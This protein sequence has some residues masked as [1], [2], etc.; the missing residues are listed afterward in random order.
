[1]NYE[2]GAMPLK[3]VADDYGMSDEINSAISDLAS[4]KVVSK[5]SV[6]ANEAIDYSVNDLG[7]NIETGL[8]IN[9]VSNPAIIEKG[10]NKKKTSLLKLLYLIYTRQLNINQIIDDINQ[11]A[12]IL[13]CRG[14]KISYLDTHQHIHIVPKILKPVIT[15]A[16]T[17]G[18]DSIRC[19]TMEKK[20]LC[21]Y[22]YSLIR[23]GFLL[24]VPKMIFL[25]SLGN[26]MRLRLDKSKMNYCKN[27]IL[28][29][30]AISG[31]YL[32]L[33]KELLKKFRDKDAELVIHPGLECET[34][35]IDNYSTG[36]Y[37]EYR[38]IIN[39]MIN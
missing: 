8:H 18:I 3:I 39:Q 10:S 14:F 30:L 9:L 37:I 24:Q 31:D 13:E 21:F 12:E 34:I 5:V 28:M 11:Q 16:K 20:Y 35:E 36:R 23:F 25:Y 26:L 17:K 29:P 33:L 1:M 38:S 7:E 15:Y 32:G 6:M 19:I 22:F 27:L 4:K 2:L